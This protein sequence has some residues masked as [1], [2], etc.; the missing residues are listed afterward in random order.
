MRFEG[1]NGGKTAFCMRKVLYGILVSIS[2]FLSSVAVRAADLPSLP[3]ASQIRTGSLDNGIVYYIVTNGSEKGKANVALVQKSGYDYETPRTAGSSAVYAMGALSS[4]PHFKSNSP[5]GYLSRNCIWPGAGGYVSV[6]P[7][8]TVYRFENIELARSKE[9]VDSTLLLVFDIIGTQSEDVGGRYSPGNQAIIISGDVDAGAVINKMT[10]LSLLVTRRSHSE[11][12][13]DYVWN[14]T[15]DAKYVNHP[16]CTPGLS[17]VSAEYAYPRTPAGNMNTVQPIVSQ[18]YAAELGIV[19]KKRITKALRNAG[20]PFSDI[21][22]SY[23]SSKDGAGD[24]RFRIEIVTSEQRVTEAAGILSATLAAI[25]A[26]GVAPEEYRDAQTE[27]VMNLKRD[28]TGDNISNSRYVDQCIA[29]YLYGASLASA[30]TTMQFFLTKNIQDDLGAR[31]FNNFVSALLDKS[32][33]LTLE[34]RADSLLGLQIKDRFNSSWVAEKPEAYKV[35]YGDT[36]KLKKSAAKVKL[37]SMNVEPLSGG[38][39]WLFDNGLKVIFK[40]TPKT[41]MFHYMWVLKGG[42]SL[43]PGL[44]SGEGAYVSDMMKLYNLPGMTCYSFADMLSANGISMKGEVTMS[45]LRV[46]GSAPSS[47]LTLLL[48]SLSSLTGS[49]TMNKEAFDYYRECQYVKMLKKPSPEAALDSLLYPD[50]AWSPYKRNIRISDDFQ[51]R[52][53]KFFRSEFSKM[54]DG[55]LIIVGDFDEFDL[56]KVLGKELGGFSTDK[57]TSFRSRIQYRTG[58]GYASKVIVGNREEVEFGVSVPLTYTALNYMTSYVAAMALQDRLNGTLAAFGWSGR[59][60][61]D[62][63][64]LPEERFN[65]RMHGAITERT[66]VP[67]SL[68]QVDSVEQVLSGMRQALSF[69]KVSATEVAVYKSILLKSIEARISDPE[70]I[71]SML[72]LRYSYGKDLVTKYK[73]NISAVNADAVNALLGRMSQE[74]T[75]GYAVRTRLEGEHIVEPKEVPVYAVLIPELKA[76]SDSLGIACEGYRA[77]GIDKSAHRAEWLDSSKFRSFMPMLPK[78]LQL[79]EK[80]EPV[81]AEEG[82]AAV[83]VDS[84]TVSAVDSLKSVLPVSDSLKSVPSDSLKSVQVAADSLQNVS[85]KY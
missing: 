81:K 34:T 50:N 56:K 27:L 10:M 35:N 62:F 73:E 30:S 74:R 64:M 66:G 43:V 11:K 63:R 33:D 59:A 65:F 54:N 61:W 82:N 1:T 41:G 57:A 22:Y 83:V 75:A 45:D 84:A 13:K 16:A 55:V 20:V 72:A 32:K 38:Q 23:V 49:G 4:L 77:I 42:Y 25:D 60:D 67:A 78:P 9:L 6:C 70:M 40:N 36:L 31:L 17:S 5:F 39:V 48:K 80:K 26:Y 51:K 24:E 71:M 7:D 37:K 18:K 28:Y 68:V 29:A 12:S 69:A 76:S 21:K 3:A 44:K 47:K 52:T 2:V 14:G 19:L 85:V 8:A 53:D 58:S 79:P 46:S 15:D